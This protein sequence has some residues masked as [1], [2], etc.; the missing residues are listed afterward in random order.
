MPD[1]I[2]APIFVTLLA[3]Q[4]AYTV[5]AAIVDELKQDGRMPDTPDKPVRIIVDRL[6]TLG[7][8]EHRFVQYVCEDGQIRREGLINL[9][10]NDKRRAITCALLKQKL[11]EMEARGAL[12]GTTAGTMGTL[13]SVQIRMIRKGIVI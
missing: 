6:L 12:T 11:E 13:T 7:N 2:H 4:Q 8:R 3:P 10:K 1:S 5:A 9:S